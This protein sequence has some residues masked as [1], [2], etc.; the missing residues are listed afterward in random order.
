MR[1]SALVAALPPEHA[2][3]SR[4]AGDPVVRGI[5][6]DSRAVAPGDAFF[7]PLS[8]GPYDLDGD[9]TVY[10]AGLKPGASDGSRIRAV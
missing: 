9:V 8:A 6:Y 10:R 7:A 1:L 5:R 4:P 3:R 2:P